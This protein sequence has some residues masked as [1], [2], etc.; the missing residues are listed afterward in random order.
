VSG[1]SRSLARL[2]QGG[3]SCQSVDKTRL[4]GRSRQIP[5]PQQKV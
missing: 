4:P 1:K 2:W 3:H 5:M